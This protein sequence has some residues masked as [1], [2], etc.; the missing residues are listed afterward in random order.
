[1]A[2]GFFGFADMWQEF[3]PAA[4]IAL[5][6]VVLLIVGVVYLLRSDS[7]RQPPRD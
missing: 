4:A 7:G 5:L 1:V 6:V 2:S 3:G